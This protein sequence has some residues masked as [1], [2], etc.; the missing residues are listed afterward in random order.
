VHFVRTE[1]DTGPIIAQAVVPIQPGDDEESLAARILAVEHRL[2]PLAVR[3]IAEGRVRVAT[4]MVEID[5]WQA[6]TI[7]VLNPVEPPDEPL[8]ATLS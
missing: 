8:A 3:L 2:Y 7:T 4:D 5:G 1:V 6:P